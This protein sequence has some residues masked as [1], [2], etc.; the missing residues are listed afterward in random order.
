MKVF[1]VVTRY[2]ASSRQ[3]MT[4][5]YYGRLYKIVPTSGSVLGFAVIAKADA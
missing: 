3:T 5:E 2:V 4:V 1:P